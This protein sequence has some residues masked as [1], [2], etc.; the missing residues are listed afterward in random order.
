MS[1]HRVCSACRVAHQPSGLWSY[2]ERRLT[3]PAGVTFSLSMGSANYL[4]GLPG[5]QTRMT[6]EPLFSMVSHKVGDPAKQRVSVRSEGSSQLHTR[7]PDRNL[8]ALLQ[9]LWESVP[10][11]ED[12]IHHSSRPSG[13]FDHACVVSLLPSLPMGQPLSFHCTEA[14]LC[15]YR[16][17]QRNHASG[18]G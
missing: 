16:V 15:I 9:C 2:E 4:M 12:N 14:T 18:D 17:P 8:A 6:S 10:A 13:S 7:G 3:F 1:L 11:A 5:I